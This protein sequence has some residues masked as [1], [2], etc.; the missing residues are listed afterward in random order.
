[1]SKRHKHPTIEQVR[2]LPALLN[3]IIPA[4]W[5]D[6]NGHVNVTYYMD[7]YNRAG[8]PMFDLLGINEDYFNKRKM[9][10]V[11]LENH[12][13]YFRELHVGNNVS[14]HCRLIAYDQKKFHGMMIVTN[15]NT[16]EIAAT[17][18][19]LALS[20]DLSMRK[21]APIP[22]DVVDGLKNQVQIS[23]LRPSCR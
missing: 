23:D 8:W 19:F 13:R 5:E 17:V 11:D 16:E 20:V 6:D 15:N 18:E 21:S 1:M 12:I 4:R 3:E 9:G 10:I 7:L 14:V 22:G 2:E